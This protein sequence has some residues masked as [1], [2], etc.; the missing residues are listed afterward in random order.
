ML[1]PSFHSTLWTYLPVFI[2][3]GRIFS[4]LSNF[5]RIAGTRNETLWLVPLRKE[6]QAA[7]FLYLFKMPAP[8][9]QKAH[10]WTDDQLHIPPSYSRAQGGN[11]LFGSERDLDDCR[12]K[13][14]L[15]LLPKKKSRIPRKELFEITSTMKLQQ[16]HLTRSKSHHYHFAYSCNFASHFLFKPMCKSM[17]VAYAQNPLIHLYVGKVSAFNLKEKGGAR[18]SSS[19]STS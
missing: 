10:I 5:V 19:N 3:P 7:L 9:H 16:L 12:E 14:T 8:S 15:L 4:S 13:N 6:R 18:Y 17:S 11:T 2:K 1:L